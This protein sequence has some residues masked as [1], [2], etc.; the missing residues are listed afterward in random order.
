MPT[1]YT[2]Q[3]MAQILRQAA[4]LRWG[5][6]ADEP[7]H[8]LEDLQLVAQQLGISPQLVERAA[9]ALTRIPARARFWKFLFGRSSNFSTSALVGH[10]LAGEAFPDLVEA[11]RKFTGRE[12]QAGE[13][14][15]SLEWRDHRDTSDVVITVIPRGPETT[16]RVFGDF[17]YWKLGPFAA[18]ALGVVLIVV[19]VAAGVNM[20][21]ASPLWVLGLGIAAA[22]VLWAVARFYWTRLARKAA[23]RVISYRK[24]TADAIIELRPP[25]PAG[26]SA[27]YG[28]FEDDRESSK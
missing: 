7:R 28:I 18:G 24:Q 8:T 13:L 10:P 16:V 2:D 17:D 26:P 23:R 9:S 22:G 11:I 3:E 4:A 12:G 20:S 1:Q 27:S 14:S 19:L 15:G 5:G 25:V 21:G 6:E